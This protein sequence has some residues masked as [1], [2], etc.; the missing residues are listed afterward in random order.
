MR[1]GIDISQIVYEGT[2]VAR[3]MENIIRELVKKDQQNEY[4]L[5]GASLRKQQKLTAYFQKIENLNSQVKLKLFPIPPFIL[6]IIW[7]KLHLLPIESLIGQVDIFWSSDWT[8]PP[9]SHAIGVTTVH[10]L[11]YLKYPNETHPSTGFSLRH[12][13]L[14]PN[15]VET[16]KRRMKWVLHECQ[17]IF[18][19]SLSTKHDLIK[20]LGVN[21]DKITVIY[22]GI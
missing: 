20:E 12:F 8:Q 10:D 5:F 6:D 7:N 18:C 19:D 3:Y 1:I 11:I 14:K 22:P 17:Q 9:L 4:V 16:Q 21:S 2:G 13:S 15:I